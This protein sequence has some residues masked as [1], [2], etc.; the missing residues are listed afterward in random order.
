MSRAFGDSWEQCS[1]V[2][3][4]SGRRKNDGEF[5]GEH[6]SAEE[7]HVIVASFELPK[8]AEDD[9]YE[10]A[11]PCLCPGESQK[12][13]KNDYGP[14]ELGR[15]SPSGRDIRRSRVP[16][17]FAQSMD[18]ENIKDVAYRVQPVAELI[19]WSCTS[20]RFAKS[21]YMI[22]LEREPCLY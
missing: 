5:G 7:C 12:H 13:K 11:D 15:N 21:V 9:D 19:V 6:T 1:S 8:N 14:F 2:V 18:S 22:V 17:V 4:G 20:W 10:E 3:V 16:L